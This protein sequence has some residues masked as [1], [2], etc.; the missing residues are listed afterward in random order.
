MSIPNFM[1]TAVSNQDI[2]L[3]YKVVPMGGAASQLVLNTQGLL[4][5]CLNVYMLSYKPGRQKAV[6]AVLALPVT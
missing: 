1:I 6:S 2:T 3:A 5:T 4:V